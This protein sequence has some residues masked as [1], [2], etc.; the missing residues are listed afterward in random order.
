MSVLVSPELPP[1][2]RTRYDEA[3]AAAQTDYE[4][5]STN[6][7]DDQGEDTNWR[8]TPRYTA[9]SDDEFDTE[10]DRSAPRT[11]YELAMERSAAQ[12]TDGNLPPMYV[13][14]PEP[15]QSSAARAGRAAP[16]GP[17]AAPF[18]EPST[19]TMDQQPWLADPHP[20]RPGSPASTA[21]GRRHGAV[22]IPYPAEYAAGQPALRGVQFGY[23]D[24]PYAITLY[25]TPQATAPLYASVDLR[26]DPLLP[27]ATASAPEEREELFHPDRI[28]LRLGA[29]PWFVMR[30][31]SWKV[32]LQSLAWYG[33]TTLATEQPGTRLYAQIAFCLPR[34]ADAKPYEPAPAFV[35]LGLAL[36][37]ASPRSPQPLESYVQQAGSTLSLISL[38]DHPLSLPTDFVTLAQTLF[39]AP[40]LSTAPALRELRQAIAKQEEWVDVRR[41][42]LARASDESHVDAWEA[43]MLH[44]QLSLLQHPEGQLSGTELDARSGHREQLRHRV[45][46]TFA[47]WSSNASSDKDLATWITPYDLSHQG[48]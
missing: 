38:S 6:S 12:P 41:N 20:P 9:P 8:P 31:Y 32:L 1:P 22:G 34:R 10:A 30:A 25:A 18:S 37:S 3:I 42:E 26:K 48:E 29:R 19:Y 45:K 2:Q 7:W 14:E 17:S 46:K 35:S 13:Q 40:Q 21:S 27:T 16:A 43:S 23:A 47:R 15:S 24:S 39:S 44:S 11:A 28:V 33:H 36:A 5:D 4:S